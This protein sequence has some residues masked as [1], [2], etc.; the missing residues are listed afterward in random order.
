MFGLTAQ[1]GDEYSADLCG[2][3]AT[4]RVWFRSENQVGVTVDQWG[5]G[6]LVLS[7]VGVA[8]QK[9]NGAAMA[10]LTFYGVDDVAREAVGKR[11]TDWWSPR[12]P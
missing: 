8:E 7:H 5:D 12:Y 1:V 9:P 11:W 3:A 2:E 4:G 6:L 10:V